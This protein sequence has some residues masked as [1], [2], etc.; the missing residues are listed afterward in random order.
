MQDVRI[1]LVEVD[2]FLEGGLIVVV[3]RQ[4]S[5]IVNAR[6]FE[7]PPRLNFKNVV[8]AVAILTLLE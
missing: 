8:V 3:Q 6:T 7:R 1:C 4:P 2:A 5:E